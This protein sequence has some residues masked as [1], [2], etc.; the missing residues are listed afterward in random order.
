[1][2]P[3]CILNRSWIP[4]RG[5]P[6]PGNVIPTNRLDPIALNV[7]KLTPAPN[8]SGFPNYTENVTS[9][10]PFDQANVRIDHYFR[11]FARLFGRWTYEPTNV[12]SPAFVNVDPSSTNG[13][14]QN[15]AIGFDANTA[16]FFNSLRFGHTRY[17]AYTQNNVPSGLTPQSLGFPLDQYQADPKGQFF[18][19][20]N[21]QIANYAT[22]FNGF[23]Q[24]PGTPNGS[25]IRHYEIGDTMTLV[26]GNHTLPGAETIRVRSS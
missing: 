6:F 26:R 25:N 5:V 17:D 3:P 10:H 4:Q 21:F 24:T 13:S 9:T 14:A 20:P 2:T 19:I 16:H 15:V 1:M 23:G 8:E 12:A 11:S 7:L 22:G 18:G